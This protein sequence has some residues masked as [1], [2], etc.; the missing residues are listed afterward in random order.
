MGDFIGGVGSSL[1]TIIFFVIAISVLVSVHEYGHF[2]VARRCGVKVEVFSIGFGREIFGW[3]D[4]LGTRW[5]ISMLPLGGYVRFFGDAD[6]TSALPDGTIAM[7]EAERKVSFAGQ[8]VGKRAAIAAAGP[9]ANFLLAIV[10]FYGLIVALGQP[11][12]PPVVDK[13]SPGSAA[14]AAGL[15]PGDRILAVD[16]SSVER[17]EDLIMV[18]RLNQGTPVRLSVARAGEQLEIGATPTITEIDNGQ[19]GKQ[20]IGLLGVSSS[21]VEFKEHGVVDSLWYAVREVG[22]V[23]NVTATAVGQMIAGSRGTEELG[24]PLR[25]AD[26]SGRVA[27]VG[28]DSFI[29]LIAALSVNL[30][31]FNLLPVPMLDGGHLLFYAFEAIR[32]RPLGDRTQ[33]FGFRVGLAMVLTLMV[34]ATW[35]D[36]VQ[37][38]VVDF[39]SRLFT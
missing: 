5:R 22:S 7:T 32:G 14:E 9:I 13:V 28:I 33:E 29:L 36:L 16:G 15:L 19:G 10:L 38:R 8:S 21:G 4:R 20:K 3:T 26:M 12:T 18:I 30:A 27:K 17:F 31:L 25:I 35:N 23:V 11:F 2:W 6:A 1:H 37:L 39:I 24:G 34:F